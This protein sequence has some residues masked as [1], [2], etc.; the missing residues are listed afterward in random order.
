[1]FGNLYLTEKHG[2]DFTETDERLATTLAA[3]A[4]VAIQNARL[5]AD[6]Q[7]HL[8]ALERAFSELSSARGQRRDRLRAASGTILELVAA[9]A[10]GECTRGW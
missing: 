8:L 4:G 1:M 2:G 3:Q 6:T 5:F 9:Q 10:C 7:E